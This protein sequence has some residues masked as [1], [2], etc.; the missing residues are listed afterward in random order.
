MAKKAKIPKLAA[1]TYWLK[2][3]RL[4]LVTD[5]IADITLKLYNTT[6]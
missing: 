4:E 1:G 3:F 6:F 2:A 5:L